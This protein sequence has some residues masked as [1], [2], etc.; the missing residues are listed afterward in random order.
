M[1]TLQILSSSALLYPC[2]EASVFV[3]FIDCSCSC[4]CSLFVL[5]T[6]HITNFIFFGV[7]V[8][9]HR[10]ASDL[11]NG[12][13]DV[14]L[15]VPVLHMG[16]CLILSLCLAPFLRLFVD[17]VGPGDCGAAG[18]GSFRHAPVSEDFIVVGVVV[19]MPVVMYVVVRLVRYGRG[20]GRLVVCIV[21][22]DG[23]GYHLPILEVLV[24]SFHAALGWLA[25][26]GAFRHQDDEDCGGEDVFHGGGGGDDDDG[27]GGDG[28]DG[29][30]RRLKWR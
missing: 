5:S 2:T 15:D 25:G 6:L 9:L 19:V 27:G 10:S 22:A 16:I 23:R 11:L 20:R 12:L 8:F 7:V 1:L 17:E 14:T 13:F 26:E 24:G 29:G 18:R 28:D 21:V 4:S 3:G 30:R